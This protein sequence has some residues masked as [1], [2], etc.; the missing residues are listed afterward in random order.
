MVEVELQAV[1][2]GVGGSC[3]RGDGAP[4]QSLRAAWGSSVGCAGSVLIQQ[5]P[6]KHWAAPETGLY[7]HG[8][9]QSLRNFKPDLTL[10]NVFQM[11]QHNAVSFV[12]EG[13]DTGCSL[14]FC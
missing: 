3:G 11:W 13:P 1:L 4:G 14:S 5:H 12:T 6:G 10:S 9:W 2:G 8:E 7:P